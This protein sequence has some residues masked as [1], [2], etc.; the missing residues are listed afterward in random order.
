MATIS[1]TDI[2]FNSDLES[3]TVNSIFAE[4]EDFLNGTTASADITVT[5]AVQGSSVTDGTATLTSGAFTGLTNLTMSGTI[6]L[7]TNTILDGT[8]TG[9]WN[10]GSGTIDTTGEITAGSMVTDNITVN[11]NIISTT[12]GN[13]SLN[14]VAGSSVIIDG[15]ANFDSG[16]VTGITS[17]T[18][19]T[20]TDGTATITGGVGSGFTS[21]TSTTLTDGTATV[22][23]GV[24]SGF[25]SFTSTSLTD[26]TAT[27]TGGVGSGFTSFT[28]T[29]IT[30]TLQTASQS[31]ITSLGTLTSLV[32]SG[33]LTVDT[34][35]F[36]VDSTNNRV[37]LGTA[38]PAFRLDVRGSDATKFTGI[39]LRNTDTTAGT[40]SVLQMPVFNGNPGFTLRQSSNAVG[41]S[42]ATGAYDVMIATGQGSSDMHF[43]A[44]ALVTPDLTISSEGRVGIGSSSPVSTA[45]LEISSTTRGFLPP[46]M[47]TTQRDAISS[48][49]A[50]LVIYNTTTSKINLYTGSWEAVT[51]A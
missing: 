12:A 42:W 19:T 29:S 43:S 13:L 3:A 26:G 48:P 45:Q 36:H 27:I 33:D 8:F 44:G 31:N 11:G 28:S 37:G 51:S 4:V 49:A 34:S 50:G 20:L 14:P 38:I 35:T 17:L 24:G 9:N 39:S 23:G 6:D 16:V 10:F 7:G 32:I 2:V 30:G 25:T 41:P 5:G 40:E 1:L 15:A 21:F 46:R 47:T 18:S 22:T